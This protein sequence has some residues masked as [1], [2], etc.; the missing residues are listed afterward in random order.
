MFKFF[1]QTFRGLVT[2]DEIVKMQ[3]K[4]HFSHIENSVSQIEN[5]NGTLVAHFQRKPQ[6]S[7]S[8]SSQWPF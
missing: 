3:S 1:A 2:W 7:V 5:D 8:I 4:K 6:H